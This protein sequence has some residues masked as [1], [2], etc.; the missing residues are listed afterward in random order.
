M[1]NIESAEVTS[2]GQKL[3]YQ[4]SGRGQP[5]IV[6]LSGHRTPLSNWNKVVPQISA[7][8]TALVYDRLDTGGSGPSKSPQ[9]GDAI[10]STLDALLEAVALVPPYILVAHSLGGLY[11]NLYARR[12][13]HRVS[14]VI[15]V[16]AGHPS[17]ANQQ[18]PDQVPRAG[19]L[20]ALLRVFTPQF[21][22]NPNSEFNNVKASV[23]QIETAPEFPTIPV[24]VIT[25]VIKMPFVPEDSFRS[26][27]QWQKQLVSLSSLGYQVMAEKSG[28]APQISEP[29]LIVEAIANAVE[30]VK[31]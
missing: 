4:K 10:L 1:S 18:A 19:L 26:H 28:H 12:N 22:T 9:D 23:R 2:A 21:K 30:S 3:K 5:S 14:A 6:F 25:G 24:A 15:M 8:G 31:P 16:E 7:M 27:L 13:P 20:N 11:A 17:E 29:S